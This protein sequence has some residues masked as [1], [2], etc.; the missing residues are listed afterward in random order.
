MKKILN[1]GCGKETYGTHFIDFY[2]SRQNVLKCNVDEE[3]FPFPDNYFD[4]VYAKFIFEHLRNPMN[5]LSESY[6]VLKKK[7]KLLS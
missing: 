1:V 3:K 2:P 7:V 5:F 4:E 6:R